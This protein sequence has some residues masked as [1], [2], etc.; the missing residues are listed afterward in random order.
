MDSRDDNLSIDD[1]LKIWFVFVGRGQESVA[2]G[3]KPARKKGFSWKRIALLL[4]VGLV[5]FLLF[6]ATAVYV[7]LSSL[8][9][10]NG[11]TIAGEIP[12]PEPGERIHV[13]ILGVDA[14]YPEDS[15]AYIPPRSDT[16]FLATLDPVTF[17]ANVVFIPRDTWAVIPG[18]PEPEKIGHAFAHGGAKLAIDTVSLLLDIPVHYYILVDFAG[19][20]GIIDTI[21][22]VPMYIDRDMYYED[23]TQDLV[24]DIPAGDH[25]MDGETALHY[26]RY[27]GQHGSDIERIDRQKAFLRVVLEELLQ[28]ETVLRLP[29]LARQVSEHVDTNMSPS[30]MVS[31]VNSATSLSPDDVPM[32]MVPGDAR[33]HERISYWFPRIDETKTM[34][35]TLIRGLIREENGEITVEVLNG[36]GIPGV[37]VQ[38]ADR[39]RAYGYDV[40][41]V[42]NAPDMRDEK[43]E[44]TRV[45]DR[46]GD[47]SVAGQLMVR[48]V[49]SFLSDASEVELYN[50]QRQADVEDDDDPAMISVYVGADYVFEP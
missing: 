4:G 27:R 16:I 10:E 9:G 39:L 47:D 21:G 15:N 33:Y 3:R 8:S 45:V 25:N 41:H 42:G 1:P 40:V 24:I 18:R 49:R 7:F 22:G 44:Y 6:A 31:F 11:D 37:A 2:T 14:E 20:A 29:D 23:P 48:A 43:Y 5:F 12:A 36:G 38:V 46:S 30:R 50:G 28:V 17:E 13:L 35:D 26:V 34:V 32:T 19:F